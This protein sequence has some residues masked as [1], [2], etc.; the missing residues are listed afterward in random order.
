MEN[1]LLC[2]ELQPQE[3]G[4]SDRPTPISLVYKGRR[5]GSVQF[6]GIGRYDKQDK[7][8]IENG[9]GGHAPFGCLF[10][11]LDYVM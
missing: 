9:V 6:V 3:E 7:K 2:G 5:K 8:Y 11:G 10:I 1:Y 4:V